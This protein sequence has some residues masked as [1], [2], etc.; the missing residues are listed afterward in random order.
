MLYLRQLAYIST[1][2]IEL[3]VFFRALAEKLI[4]KFM[5]G[6]EGLCKVLPSE[7]EDKLAETV[8]TMNGIL[9]KMEAL[10]A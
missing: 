2:R 3:Q 7:D 10:N 4:D 5:Q 6:L 8:K 9:K 1:A